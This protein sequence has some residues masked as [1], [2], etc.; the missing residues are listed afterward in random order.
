MNNISIKIG[1]T[2][3]NTPIMGASGCAGW[4]REICEYNEKND[5]GGF[6]SKSITL[7]EKKGNEGKRIYETYGGLL[8]SIGLEN[9]GL[10]YFIDYLLPEISEMKCAVFLNLAFFDVSELHMMMEK[11][12][13][14][15]GFDGYEINISCPNVHK[16]GF[17]I[18]SSIEKSDKS[19]RGLRKL[20]DKTLIL[21]LSP[22]FSESFRIAQI[23][24]A[25][26]FDG[27]TFTNTY[28]GTAVNIK[29]KKF[30]FNNRVA[31]YSGPA[32][33]PMSLWNVHRMVNTVKI[34][35]IGAGGINCI[36]DV[37]EYLIVGASAVQVGTSL[38]VKPGILSG[39][40]VQL[41][42]YCKNNNIEDI[43]Q[44][45]GSVERRKG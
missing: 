40:S 7:D 14:H 10:N 17:N 31:G 24:E 2:I 9:P 25:E 26:G 16:G 37:L 5:F 42:D 15:K 41:R 6:V 38:L 23:A 20:T 8:N 34:P 13:Q 11:L 21:K 28:L 19:I 43:S 1:K 32:I 29:E 44:I 12:E 30:I 45:I 18:N 3:L 4:G 35:V 22:A 39:L 36:N 33:K 27:I